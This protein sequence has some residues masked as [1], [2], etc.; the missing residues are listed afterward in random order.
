M[1]SLLAGSLPIV[2]V[3]VL[4]CG[5]PS[6]INASADALMVTSAQLGGGW[7]VESQQVDTT[8]DAVTAAREVVHPGPDADVI[9]VVYVFGSATNAHTGLQTIL[10]Q[11][12]VQG[13]TDANSYSTTTVFGDETVSFDFYNDG[14]QILLWRRAN[15]VATVA[16]SDQ[17]TG[18][19]VAISSEQSDNI[20]RARH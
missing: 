1:R 8:Y 2:A 5:G 14:N 17:R 12:A 18:E 20:D 3:F 15:V 4:G 19:V 11:L 7:A 9:I 13:Q 10:A 16:G 6:P